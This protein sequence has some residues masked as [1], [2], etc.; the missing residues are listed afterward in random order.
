MQNVIWITNS[1]GKGARGRLYAELYPVAPNGDADNP[2]R[3]RAMDAVILN[4]PPA[5][6]MDA[7]PS[8]IGA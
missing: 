5:D 8:S 1:T 4:L 6:E 7:P 2:A 3:N